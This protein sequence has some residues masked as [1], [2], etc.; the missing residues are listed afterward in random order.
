MQGFANVLRAMPWRIGRV[1]TGLPLYTSDN[2]VSRY[3]QPLALWAGFSAFTYF[4]PLSPQ[5]LMRIGPGVTPRGIGTREH[6]DFSD[7]ETSFA[8]HVI[9]AD[10]SRF[11]YGAG[12]HVPLACARHCVERV[13]ATKTAHAA[14]GF[15]G[16][17]PP[18]ATGYGASIL[19][20]HLR[21]DGQDP[22]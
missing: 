19:D 6:K 12:P 1:D 14:A 11:L 2:P 13:T 16:G 20:G 15:R 22:V 4:F 5:T 8:R 21:L 17:L 7:W 3:R 9:T 18:E 10:A